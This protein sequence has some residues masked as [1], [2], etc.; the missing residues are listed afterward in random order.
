MRLAQ[1]LA[2]LMLLSAPFFSA[3][4]VNAQNVR[5]DKARI[6]VQNA[7]T[8]RL[9]LESSGP[10]KPTV[11]YLKDPNRIVIDLPPV[12]FALGPGISDGKRFIDSY[13]YGAFS[14]S[15]SRLVIDLKKPAQVK[16]SF[17]IPPSKRV[18]I[19]RTVF[20]IAITNTARFNKE[21][22]RTAPQ[23]VDPNRRAV[24]PELSAAARNGNKP[25]I[26]IDAGHGGN[27]PGT[28]GVNGKA[29]KGIA[30]SVARQLAKSLEATGKFTP[31][32]TRD[33]DIYVDLRRRVEIARANKADLM[34]SLHA[35]S[36]G[37]KRLRGGTIYTL[38]EKAS[39]DEAA[40]LAAKE[41]KADIIA[42]IDLDMENPFV[43]DILI[44]L[45]QRESKNF[46]V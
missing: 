36:I 31:V 24:T 6:G 33:R 42:G 45:A 39:D 13:R 2:L 9:V 41:N 11:S 15:V 21:V 1:I 34:L 28:M 44:T 18:S 16:K 8:L 12:Q 35:D 5:V 40:A 38:S 46:S 14:N 32:L 19:H 3:A 22:T 27:D 10:L 25:V 17:S 29:E 20:D 7:T 30:L 26:A 4:S 37:N 23:L 43:R